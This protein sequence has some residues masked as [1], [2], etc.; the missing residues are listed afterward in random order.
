MPA[1]RILTGDN[2]HSLL[3]R[4]GF[5]FPEDDCT[6]APHGERFSFFDGVYV[7]GGPRVVVGGGHSAE[8]K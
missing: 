3:L 1:T 8:L 4:R 5:L 7:E 6:D 2:G